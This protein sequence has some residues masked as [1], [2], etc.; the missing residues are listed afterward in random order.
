MKRQYKVFLGATGAVLIFSIVGL[1]SVACGNVMDWFVSRASEKHID[2][3]ETAA[4]GPSGVEI[5]FEFPRER[6]AWPFYLVRNGDLDHVEAPINV[7]LFIE[8]TGENPFWV[9]RRE[10]DSNERTRAKV[11]KNERELI[12]SGDLEI[13]I[14]SLYRESR[15]REVGEGRFEEWP[16]LISILHDAPPRGT[17]LR[18]RLIL[19]AEE[20][21]ELKHPIMWYTY[22]PQDTL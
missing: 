17:E 10:L 21:M 20:Y 1:L 8:N 9:R 2:L 12:Y 16:P 19:E 15:L 14:S 13:L 4:I 11:L 6:R 22:V 3:G 7:K 5:A 18:G